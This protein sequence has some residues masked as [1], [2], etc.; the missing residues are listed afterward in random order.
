MASYVIDNATHYSNRGTRSRTLRYR[1]TFSL[2][3]LDNDGSPWTVGSTI[4]RK[5]SR[6]DNSPECWTEGLR[7][8][9]FHRAKL[10]VVSDRI[11]QVRS[12]GDS[13]SSC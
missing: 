6:L 3:R 9:P 10:R 11:P 4:R 1:L 13:K 2:R 12:H 7:I 8:R 5:S